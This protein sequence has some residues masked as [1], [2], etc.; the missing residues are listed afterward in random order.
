M[1]PYKEKE[2]KKSFLSRN[3][4]AETGIPAAVRRNKLYADNISSQEKTEIVRYWSKQLSVLAKKYSQ[5]QTRETFVQ[6]A[7]DLMHKMNL[8]FKD[9]FASSGFRFSHAQKSLS[10]LLKYRW[11]KEEIAEPPI[12]PIDRNVLRKMPS[13]FKYWS[14]TKLSEDNYLRVYTEL[15]RMAEKKDCSVAQMELE[16]FEDIYN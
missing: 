10:V 13:P 1:T 9:S 7:R 11:C 16:W 6:D 8:K 2:L 15:E 12:C 3:Q 4:L 14:W 5:K